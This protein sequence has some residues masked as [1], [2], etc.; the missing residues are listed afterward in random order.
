MKK[1]FIFLS[2]LA[3]LLLFAGGRAAHALST[4]PYVT[5]DPQSL[6]YP[7]GTDAEYAA[8]VSGE[9]LTFTWYVEY[10]GKDYEMPADK[11]KLMN[12]GMQYG[13]SDIVIKS[14]ANRT[15]ITFK[16]ISL[17]IGMKDSKPT[18][19]YCHAFDGNTG[20]D[21]NY[22]HVSCSGYGLM[23][24]GYPPMI[25]VR[26]V[27]SLNPD[28]VGKIAV[29]VIDVDSNYVSEVNYQWYEYSGGTY[30]TG[31]KAIPGEDG[32]IYISATDPGEWE[33]LVVGVQ[34]VLKGGGDYWCYSSPI[35]VVRRTGDVDYSHDQLIIRKTPDRKGYDLGDKL[36]LTGLQAEY[37][38]DGKSQGF[39]PV[40]SLETDVT[41]FLYAGPVWVTVGYKG[42]TNGFT[43]W[44]EPKAGDW[45]TE[46]AP[47]VPTTAEPTTAEPTTSE[48][49]TAEPTT[50]EAPTEEPTAAGS[51]AEEPTQPETTEA[52]PETGGPDPE[53][54]ETAPETAETPTESAP[55][56]T[57]EASA[58]STEAPVSTT[59][60]TPQG[61]GSGN[62]VVIILIIAMALIIGLLAG[63]L[64]SKKKEK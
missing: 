28:D 63:V 20:A 48:P 42:Q 6:S 40:T 29:D 19:V 12:A 21:T 55:A 44:V 34:F 22:A 1:R 17:N 54:T 58:T 35:S 53:T 4:E 41:S 43:V 64:I 27:V 36:D 47:P 25:Y 61:G 62:T 37:I 9:N 57:T 24:A 49:T 14:S 60:E 30:M 46:P 3:V 31:I 8:T 5:W 33:D 16:N 7:V 18:R 51:T 15:S 10:G 39:V 56:P 11:D 52:V 50:A 26:P 23:D 13:C 59:E 2:A 45:E 38:A 32:M